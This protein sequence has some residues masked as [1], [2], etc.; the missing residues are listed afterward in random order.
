MP[1]LI[2]E[3]LQWSESFTSGSSVLAPSFRGTHRCCPQSLHSSP[4]GG[5]WWSLG[6]VV[7]LPRAH[8][9]P[10]LQLL[11]TRTVH[12]QVPLPALLSMFRPPPSDP[13][14]LLLSQTR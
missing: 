2:S 7:L 4:V 8:K 5:C 3:V 10:A 12:S 11:P 1:V 9:S 6:W 13:T 14:Q